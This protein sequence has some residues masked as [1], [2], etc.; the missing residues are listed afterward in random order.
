MRLLTVIAGIIVATS[1]ACLGSAL[2]APVETI[3]LAKA[4][5]LATR[6][7]PELEIMQQRI[8]QAQAKRQ[9]A[10]ALVKPTLGV[11]AQYSHHDEHLELDFSKYIPA[12]LG[13]DPGEPISL[14]ERNQFAL[15]GKLSVPIFRGPAYPLISAAKKGIRV[16]QLQQL[17]SRQDYLYQIARL[18][19]GTL[20]RGEL[21]VTLADKVTLDH[22]LLKLEE[23]RVKAGDSPRLS[24]LRAKFSLAQSQQRLADEEIAKAASH[25][26]LAIL[27]GITNDFKLVMPVLKSSETKESKIPGAARADLAA[28]DTAIEAAIAQ[29]K[30]VW[31][32]FA[33]E[34]TADGLLRWDSQKG[35]SE[36]NYHADLMV[37]FRLPLYDAG[38]RY[39]KLKTARAQLAT[40]R[41]QKA[42]LSRKIQREII[43][44]RAELK[45][46][47]KI[48]SIAEQA[49]ALAKA[50]AS[51]GKLAYTQQTISQ[52]DLLDIN[53]RL[54]S[55]Q[56]GLIKSDFRIRFAHLALDH[57]RGNF[58]R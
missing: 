10:L 20:M 45:A 26:Q 13:V 35:F 53:H 2:A 1:V 5:R 38:L 31:W 21:L 37:T 51:D 27:L 34:L 22:Q 48:R 47:K 4:L 54:L 39:S 56:L 25:E 36:R 8:V 50:A 55:A 23:A 57:R 16:A 7:S 24:V 30:S 14:Q 40:R 6:N 43:Q 3:D 41:S 17:R 42:A 58:E 15:Y 49:L 29:K 52:S 44:S 12:G 18:Y 28:V 9:Q 33:P 19:L 32:S 46:A 11:Q